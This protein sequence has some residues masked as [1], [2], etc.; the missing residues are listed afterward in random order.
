[1]FEALYL[2]ISKKL[3]QALIRRVRFPHPHIIRSPLI[4]KKNVFDY[5]TLPIKISLRSVAYPMI[6]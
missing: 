4:K 2:I 6:I 1:M 3:N 5:H